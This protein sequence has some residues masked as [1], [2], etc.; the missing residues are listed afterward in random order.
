MKCI[1][2]DD[3]EVARA[4]ARHC[5]EKTPSLT[6]LGTYTNPIEALEAIKHNKPDLLLLDVEMPEMSGIDFIKTFH[7]IPQVILITS[8]K[9]YAAE[10]FDYNVT[11][12]IVK[13]IEYLRFLKAITKAKDML[14]SY[15]KE[16]AGSNELFIKV[17]NRFVHLALKDIYMVEALAD[18]VNIF[19]DKQRYTVLSTMKAI[20][21][22]LPKNDFIRV[23]RSYI[24]RI[25]KIK[26]IDDHTIVIADKN[27]PVSRN[28][29]EAL[30]NILNRL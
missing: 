24:V 12:Y 27:V 17:D 22:K 2:I 23:H 4:A 21:D 11:D 26:E 7:D 13:P 30:M 18:Y 3:N 5:V 10:A 9:D 1:I 16:D 19:T 8:K 6:L 28:Q 20:E 14:D 29:K 25:D 15:K